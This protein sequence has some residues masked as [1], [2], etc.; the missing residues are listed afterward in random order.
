MVSKTTN[1]F[2]CFCVICPLF[3]N[4]HYLYLAG[5]MLYA[6]VKLSAYMYVTLMKKAGLNIHVHVAMKRQKFWN[7]VSFFCYEQNSF[8]DCPLTGQSVYVKNTS[9]STPNML[10]KGLEPGTFYS[11]CIQAQVGGSAQASWSEVAVFATA[12]F[13]GSANRKPHCVFVPSTVCAWVCKNV[14]ILLSG[15]S[16]L[17]S[18]QY[19]PIFALFTSVLGQWLSL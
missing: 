15:E 8:S 4:L 6:S 19:L 12:G 5:L 11:V 1:F 17:Q 13:G 3:S 16:C 18:L 10:I 7:V 14:F 2:D 9:D